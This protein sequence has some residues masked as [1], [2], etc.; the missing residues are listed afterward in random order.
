MTAAE[1]PLQPHRKRH[2]LRF[3]VLLLALL[4]WPSVASA[5][6]PIPV[7]WGEVPWGPLFGFALVGAIEGFLVAVVFRV[8][9]VVAIAAMIAANCVS[10]IVGGIGLEVLEGPLDQI[11]R[12]ETIPSYFWPE[13]LPIRLVVMF[14]LALTF[15]WPFCLALLWQKRGKWWKSLVASGLAQTATYA[16]LFPVLIVC[17]VWS[18][19]YMRYSWARAYENFLPPSAWR[20]SALLLLVTVLIGVGEG[21]LIALVFKVRKVVALPLMIVA[22]YVSM[23]VGGP[24]QAVF[25]V[26]V[27]RGEAPF[28]YL[29]VPA[30]LLSV[31]LEWPFCFAVLR[32]KSGRMRKALVASGIA[33]IASYA[34]LVPLYL[35]LGPIAL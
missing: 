17:I 2:H 21:F 4:L 18:H 7:V 10:M 34:V 6:V 14:F 9:K 24:A 19:R 25:E 13:I 22:N 27:Y 15:E 28:Y 32:G 20:D 35:A 8:R 3:A 29:I 12:G 11:R 30:F 31:I 5:D 1:G 33:Q 23:M 16:V 26:L